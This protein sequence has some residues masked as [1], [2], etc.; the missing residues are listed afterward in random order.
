MRISPSGNID[1]LLTPTIYNLLILYDYY[2]L[3]I[4]IIMSGTLKM[5]FSRGNM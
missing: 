3:L 1:K 5:T 4:S 2:Y